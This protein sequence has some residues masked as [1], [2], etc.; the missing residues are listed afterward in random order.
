MSTVETPGTDETVAPTATT[1]HDTADHENEHHHPTDNRYI[2]I[3]LILA[4]ITAAEVAASYID[5][6]PV[7]LPALLGMMAVKFLIVARVFMHL[8]FDNKVFSWM[9]FTGL[10]LALFVYLA[11]LL[12]FQFF[13]G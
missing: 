6:G 10:I 12:T 5:L 4:V 8:Q 7:F 11:A 13:A 3:A 1:V 2:V 9:F